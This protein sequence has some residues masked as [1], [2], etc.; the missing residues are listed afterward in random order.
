VPSKILLLAAVVL[1]TFTVTGQG[2]GF[3]RL[4]MPAG[5][6]WHDYAYHPEW[7]AYL[8]PEA[9]CPGGEDVDASPAEQQ[10]TILCL[11]NWARAR[12]ALAALPASPVLM[13]S[14]AMK[15]SDLVRCDEFVHTPC[16]TAVEAGARSLGYVRPLGENIA[17][18][19]GP[20]RGPRATVDSWLGSPEHRL[21][22]LSPRWREQG[23]ALLHVS[24]YQGADD[25]AVW[26]SQF[27]G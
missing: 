23:I 21:N 12:D 19:T 1:L 9:E 24:R 4:Q 6:G 20:A 15:A 18:S 26:V 3:L 14:A 5:D 22:L 17:W 11:L 2:P 25:A 16:G 27:G 10:Q 13:T 8:A 7:A